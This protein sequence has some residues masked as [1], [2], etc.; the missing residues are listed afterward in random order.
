MSIYGHIPHGWSIAKLRDVCVHSDGV[1][2]GPFGSQLH[3]RDYRDEGTPII[4]VEH[5]GDNHIIHND[6][7]RI[8]DKDRHR[9]GR[10]TLRAG[11][12]VFSRVGSVDRRALVNEKE[13]GWLFSGRCLR[14]RPDPNRIDPS[15]LSWFFG[16]P[17]F[18]DH[19]RRIAVGATMPSLNTDLLSNVQIIL[20]P[21][22]EQKLISSVLDGLKYKVI[23]NHIMNRTLEEIGKALFKRWFIDFE[24]PNEESKPYK[25]SS[26]MMIDSEL[27]MI[28]LGW[29]VDK[30]SSII[31][32]YGGG[33][34]RTDIPEYWNGDIKWFTVKDTPNG[35]SRTNRT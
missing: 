3:Q 34:P 27:G 20:P 26:G 14:V 32:I 5:L 9:L 25:S 10:Y 11:D 35:V 2:T 4:T 18:T 31:N 19:I 8:S 12:I 13:E 6:L 22:D 30:M 29:Y 28:P 16:L 1:L 15:Y 24:F 7:P 17:N 33:T 21:R 23:L